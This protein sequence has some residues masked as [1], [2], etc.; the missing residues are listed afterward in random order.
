MTIHEM[1]LAP[2]MRFRAEQLQAKVPA[3]QYLSGRRNVRSQANAMATNHLEDA[4]YLVTTYR[5]GR[6]FLEAIQRLPVSAH[7]SHTHIAKALEGLMSEQPHL[8]QWTHKDGNAVD[9]LPME[10]ANGQPTREGQHVISWIRAC[11]DTT[12]FRIREGKLVR[13]HWACRA[14][15]RSEDV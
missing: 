8:L 4:T 1:H 7:R 13:W 9:L 12:D 5:N 11:P 3:V 15:D 14:G 6:L 2:L 10:D